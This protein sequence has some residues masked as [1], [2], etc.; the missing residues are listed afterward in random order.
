MSENR[1]IPLL[2][3]SSKT[4]EH[5]NTADRLA[6]AFRNSRQLPEIMKPNE[7]AG[8]NLE[9]Y[10]LV[11]ARWTANQPIPKFFDEKLV[12]RDPNKC[13]VTSTLRTYIGKHLLHIRR[14]V[15]PQHPDFVGL[16][17]DEYPPWYTK[18]RKD[19]SD[20][21]DRFQ[22]MHPGDQLFG[23]VDIRPLYHD[24]GG[25]GEEDHPLKGCHLKGVIISLVKKA[26]P[27]N[28]C[29][30]IASQVSNADDAV[31]RGGEIKFQNF[32]EWK[33]DHLMQITDTTWQESKTLENYSMP[34]L[35]D[36]DWV[37]DFYVMNGAYFM[38]EQGLF[39]FPEQVA[40][41][42]EHSVYPSLHTISDGS[43]ARRLTIAIRN[44]LPS[45]LTKAEKMRFSS[46][47]LRKG[48]ITQ[49]SL[50]PHITLFQAT[51]RTGHSTGT[52]V[53]SYLDRKNPAR[54]LPAAN[55]IHG[56]KNLFTESVVP[57]LDSIGESNS[58]AFKAL[59]NR[60]FSVNIND[61]RPG[62]KHYIILETCALSLI[63]HYPQII[64]DCGPQNRITSDLLKH[65][66]NAGIIHFG[67]PELSPISVL[68]LWSKLIN[69]D[70]DQRT[71]INTV[72]AMENDSP[73]SALFSLM[74][75]IA[76]DM[77]EVKGQH[78]ELVW[79][80]SSSKATQSKLLEEVATLH[81]KLDES[82]AA[83][84]KLSHFACM[85][86][87]P[88]PPSRSTLPALPPP[89]DT[90]I[91]PIEN[92]NEQPTSAPIANTEDMPSQVR[93]SPIF[94]EEST[95]V[96]LSSSSHAK[97]SK[98]SSRAKSSKSSSH[99]KP[100]EWNNAGSAIESKGD[101]GKRFY[102]SLQQFSEQNL[103]LDG[104]KLNKVE[105]P[106]GHGGD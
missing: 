83:N 13:C 87:S 65:A 25:R 47:S 11:F 29:L 46:K 18:L 44:N 51:A 27:N 96:N 4:Q 37:F 17:V 79:E 28:N 22:K 14:C 1:S 58:A 77:K 59:M 90:A 56:K 35:A 57:K 70:V 94:E 78:R 53:D 82:Y 63:R 100:L 21:A 68:E 2:G 5:N 72:N 103:I 10:F 66:H 85:L 55:A 97:S 19:F 60:M 3:Q 95:T 52:N 89:D 6:K 84:N 62:G 7:F 105:I 31:P 38:C 26:L 102:H 24:L 54:A 99:A 36:D 15:A 74:A 64:K 34:R 42:L 16:K 49:L 20:E 71:K 91:P 40:D 104:Q 101:K 50:H 73:N 39:R 76:R 75:D 69:D 61:F 86:K 41:G 8:D 32:N 43:V 45:N 88:E 81:Q 33:Y 67:R 48:T 30:E 12:G 23:E 106:K 80:L 9:H 92:E 98:S 93:L